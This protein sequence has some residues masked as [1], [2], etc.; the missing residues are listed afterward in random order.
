[1]DLGAEIKGPNAAPRPR[2]GNARRGDAAV[3]HAR[4]EMAAGRRARPSDRGP[5]CRCARKQQSP[6]QRPLRLQARPNPSRSPSYPLNSS[7]GRDCGYLIVLLACFWSRRP[8]FQIGSP[9]PVIAEH[10]VMSPSRQKRGFPSRPA[11]LDPRASARED[12]FPNTNKAYLIVTR[13]AR[14]RE[15]PVAN[16]GRTETQSSRFCACRGREAEACCRLPTAT[17]GPA[18]P[19]RATNT[20]YGAGMRV[21]DPGPA[22]RREHLP[23]VDPSIGA[24]TMMR[25]AGP[26]RI[27]HPHSASYRGR[28]T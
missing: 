15:T 9:P 19:D 17:R 28:T 6:R 10:C 24:A 14:P 21:I 3:Q 22:S 20:R 5:A 27:P 11:R 4:R 8:Q 1:M 16:A 13:L 23:R 25:L 12:V 2:R 26:P 7:T 18:A